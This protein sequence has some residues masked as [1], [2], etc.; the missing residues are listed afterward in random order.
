MNNNSNFQTQKPKT[1]KNLAKIF[2]AVVA[3]MF[4]LSCVNDT[5]E[6]PTIEVGNSATTIT[7]SLEESRTQLGDKDAEGKY[8]LYWSAGDAI[9]INGVAS[10]PLS[11]NYEGKASAAF[12]FDG[13]V[14]HPYNAVYPAPAE[15]VT[16]AE[17]LYP[18]TFAATQP[19]TEGT[20]APGTAPMYGYAEGDELQLNHLTG[21]LRLAIKGEA[22]LA[23]IAITAEGKIAGNFDVNC[24]T[25]ALTA[26]EDASNTVTVTFGE[27][28]ALSAEATPIYVAVPAGEHGLFNIVITSTEGEVMTAKFESSSKPIAVGIVREF[29]EIL[30]ADN[31]AAGG[32]FIIDSEEAL[33]AFAAKATNFASYNKAIVTA[34]ITLTK[35]WATIE[36]FG[37]FEFDGGGK[38]IS[39]LNAPLF[40]TTNANIH[41]LTLADVVLN[42]TNHGNSGAFA[43]RMVN[44]SLINCSASG[45]SVINCTEFSAANY[46]G[47]NNYSHGGLIGY[48]RNTTIDNCT[49]NVTIEVK[50]LS[51]SGSGKTAIGGI[52]GC[53]SDSSK[54]TNLTNNGNITYTGKTQDSTMYLSGI[55]GRNDEQDEASVRI[56][57]AL[58][59]CTNNG[60][61]STAKNSKTTGGV[62]LSGITGFLSSDVKT[63]TLSNLHN[64]NKV[65]HYGS[66]ASAYV[67]G[68]IGN[69][70]KA[71][72]K[73][74]T[75]TELV[76]V[77]SGSTASKVVRVGG[78]ASSMSEDSILENCTNS[79]TV[80]MY[81]KVTI[82]AG[83]Y[84]AVGGIAAVVSNS[85]TVS[86]C[87]NSG[88][89][90]VHSQDEAS[91][92]QEANAF[93]V[94]GIVGECTAALVEN[95][96][97]LSSATINTRNSYTGISV[98]GIIGTGG[99]GCAVSGCKNHAVVKMEKG[100]GTAAGIDALMGGICGSGATAMSFSNCENLG[101]VA[102]QQS[103]VDE[104]ASAVNIGGIIGATSTTKGT[105]ISGCKNN[106]TVQYKGK[107]SAAV[108]I[109]VG[110]IVGRVNALATT[111]A[112][113]VENCINDVNGLIDNQGC[114]TK[115][116]G[117]GGIIGIT[118]RG[119]IVVNGCKN[120]GTIQQTGNLAKAYHTKRTA[121]GNG[122]GGIVG[123][124]RQIYLLTNCE[125]YG[126]ISIANENVERIYLY[127]GGVVGWALSEEKNSGA[128]YGAL[129]M[130]DCANYADLTFGGKAELY[131][132]GGV[133]GCVMA[134]E[135]KSKRWWEEISG[136]TNIADLTFSATAEEGVG[137]AFGGAVG[138]VEV[139]TLATAKHDKIA[140][141]KCVVY[142]DLKADGMKGKAGMIM[143]APYGG[144]YAATNCQLGGSLIY[145]KEEIVTG[146]DAN[147]DVETSLLDAPG[148]M[149]VDNW[150]K[151]I[152]GTESTIETAT[153]NNCLLLNEK[154][155]VPAQ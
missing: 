48:V 75:N 119:N 74:C 107:K 49:N 85:S 76:S 82:N 37:A 138:F 112:T 23:S 117:V 139:T 47:Y 144:Q 52:V 72:L 39:G 120:Y 129:T 64:T 142:G 41:D 69:T 27:G 50:Q 150:Y 55:T 4:A 123:I 65:V 93:R 54:F 33:F 153:A 147:G 32:N 36:E 102:Y 18:V 16:A 143:G 3:G 133:V 73:D 17:G 13:E 34:N 136:L 2:F 132:A 137:Y 103:E 8:P 42:I 10:Q 38:T 78:I 21:V 19:Y 95:C 71:Y 155:A 84:V 111:D 96:E 6:D 14:A 94:G 140:I 44:G 116:L 51:T 89:I 29:K 87:K 68:I 35:D 45:T 109:G 118:L 121:V 11:E 43:R 22:T 127:V 40:G 106:A 128:T 114:T 80:T 122:F 141:D 81:P 24:Q 79:G 46:T 26:H 5:I 28:L 60:L 83:E 90:N 115:D 149:T 86:G 31:S 12:N 126:Q 91:V 77:A 15:G 151:H 56:I 135:D 154:P 57:A 30:F 100:G 108:E 53:H 145:G 59:N 7:V 146:E 1:M 66:A 105:T 92:I 97:N 113:T 25:G 98:G 124:N 99:N 58:S 125:N 148:A 61:I 104:T 134:N 9:A 63:V 110:G 152:Y 101:A 62:I 130:K 131:Y 88:P 67:G 20:F 70:A